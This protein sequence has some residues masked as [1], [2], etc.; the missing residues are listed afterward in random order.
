MA[1]TLHKVKMAQLEVRVGG[2]YGATP[3]SGRRG[4][5]LFTCQVPEVVSDYLKDETFFQV[6][7]V[8]DALG[9]VAVYFGEEL[10]RSWTAKDHEVSLARA[11]EV[12]ELDAT[13]AE[14]RTTV[15][16]LEQQVEL[17]RRAIAVAEGQVAVLMQQ[18]KDEQAAIA[19]DRQRNAGELEAIRAE[20]ERARARA[21]AELANLAQWI[22]ANR[23]RALEETTAYAGAW[24]HMRAQIGATITQVGAIAQG[25]IDRTGTIANQAG[26]QQAEVQSQA[27]ATTQLL[28]EFVGQVRSNATASISVPA[29]PGPL[30]KLMDL[31]KSL[32]EGQLGGA[33]SSLINAYAQ[34]VSGGAAPPFNDPN[35]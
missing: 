15:Q 29:G 12:G 25:I 9:A 11:A 18:R 35:G 21:D 8:P 19:A 14:R 13:I 31:G 7:P 10:L 1:E 4:V 2:R 27:L 22:Q 26:T 20:L 28:G 17:L 6:A 34:R 5:V 30:D 23:G 32:A 33:F 24:D 16:G 3:R